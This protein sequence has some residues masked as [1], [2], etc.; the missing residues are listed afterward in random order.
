MTGPKES[1]PIE[2]DGGEGE[3]GGQILR[4]SLALSLVTGRPI[5]V[6]RIR[7][8][9]RKPGLLRQHLTAVLAARDVGRARVSGAE[10]GSTEIAFEPAGVRP[11]RHRFAVGTAGS[12]SLVLQTILPALWSAAEPSEIEIEGGTHNPTAP[13]FDF[14]AR[15][16]LP[17]L[18]RLGPRVSGELLRHGFFPAG[19]GSARFSVAPAPLRPAEWLEAGA[20]VSRRAR[21]LV[22]NLPRGIAERE[23][24][25]VRGKLGWPEEA[26]AVEEI[27]TS[28]GPG[29]VVMLELANEHATELVTGFGAPDVRA[30]H[31]A[32]DAVEQARRWIAARVPVGVHLADQLVLPL[33]LAG[34][35]RFRTLALSRH[36]RTQIEL[37]RRF[38]AVRVEAIEEPGGA[39]RVEF[40][41]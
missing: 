26:L 5:R 30:E 37:V 35:G 16:F 19:G 9:R 25:V 41:T 11:G 7:A 40:G 15:V 32:G 13:P 38:V 28:I 1:G 29:N 2:I 17:A 27:S 10:L 3:G 8:G 34:G 14:L 33:A 36:A 39:T 23:L 20:P 22:A 18:E 12:V 21:A 24:E 6:R 31:V 4:T